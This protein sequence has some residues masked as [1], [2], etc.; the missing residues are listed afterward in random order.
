MRETVKIGRWKFIVLHG[1]GWHVFREKSPRCR[2]VAKTRDEA[3]HRAKTAMM[4]YI[5]GLK[6]AEG[7]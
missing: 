5:M 1:S 4:F 2:F 7:R 6:D 3:I